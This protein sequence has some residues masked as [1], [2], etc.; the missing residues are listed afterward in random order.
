MIE[1][2]V[3]IIT[4]LLNFVGFVIV[5]ILFQQI[6]KVKLTFLEWVLIIIF[7]Q[8]VSFFMNPQKYSMVALV[9]MKDISVIFCLLSVSFHHNPKIGIRY[10][11][12]YALYPINLYMILHEVYCYIIFAIFSI[13]LTSLTMTSPSV[14]KMI[15]MITAVI[16]PPI[17]YYL[18][19][20]WLNIDISNVR[21]TLKNYLS[22]RALRFVNVL[23]LLFYPGMECFGAIAPFEKMSMNRNIYRAVIFIYFILL[24]IFLFYL[25]FRHG[26]EQK[27]ELLR[28][29]EMELAALENYSKHVESLYQEVRSFRHDYAN[30]LMSLKVGIDQGNLDDIKKIY[31]EITADSTKLVKNNKFDL[32]RLANITDSGVKSLMSA[33]F[34]QAEN[35][36]ITISLEVAEEMGTPKIPLISYIR[37][38]S[39]LFD[40][41]IEAALE[42]AEP[43]ISVANF[44][45]DDEFVFMIENST[46]EKSVDLGKIFERGYS[47]KGDNRG[48]GLATLMDFQDDYENLSVETR[49]L[50]YKFTQVVRIYEA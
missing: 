11:I 38:L 4:M 48:L 22:A 46:K 24:F 29:Q 43:R 20:K 25:N 21:K 36:G 13:Q 50:D 49:S 23:L 37:I 35:Q 26:Q 45:Q 42:S 2:V 44:Y 18:I 6:T 9:L 7:L 5:G 40:N 1:I 17:F 47:T 27:N 16:I 10:H 41:A 19:S 8:A 34:L 14:G 28:N 39:I 31:D 33:K 12:F 32:T 30:I 15:G 3:F